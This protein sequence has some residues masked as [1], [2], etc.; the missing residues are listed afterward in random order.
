MT[1][2]KQTLK[3]VLAAARQLPP[4]LQQ[5]LAEQLLTTAVP[6]RSTTAVYLKHLSPQKQDRLKVLMDKNSEGQLRQAERTELERLGA[7]IDELLLANSLALART[8]RPELFNERGRPM[9][10]RLQQA[11]REPSERRLTSRRE[12]IRG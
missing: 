2:N 11:L 10:R 5:Q 9:K 8:L 6:D 12:N 3:V 4:K 7:E 1:Q